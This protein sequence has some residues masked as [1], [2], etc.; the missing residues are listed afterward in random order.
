[1]GTGISKEELNVKK[2]EIEWDGE[3]IINYNLKDLQALTK[4]I[5]SLEF[6]QGQYTL[7][8]HF[9]ETHIPDKN[10]RNQANILFTK[11][12]YVYLNK[13]YKGD[14]MKE[15]WYDAISRE[16]TDGLKASKE[17]ID[18]LKA[19]GYFTDVSTIGEEAFAKNELESVTIPDSVTT[20]GDEAFKN[21]NLQSVKIGK[22][23]KT[24]GN[25]A[26]YD[27]ELT[28]VEI[29]DGVTT[30]GER[31]FAYNNLTSLKIPDSVTTIGA[32]AFIDNN[33]LQSVKIG[34]NVKTIGGGAFYNNNLE[35]VTLGKNVK[36][37]EARAF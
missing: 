1:M 15:K 17:R 25:R 33:N 21:N 6:D 9:E 32:G 35:S 23:V 22:N 34:K 36:T 7:I 31:A 11:C 2:C 37:I 8:K 30:I 24:I 29:P 28:L 18:V 26:F 20:I 19:F 10:R 27:S 12:K 4:K 3:K 14:T 16:R 13:T 5:K